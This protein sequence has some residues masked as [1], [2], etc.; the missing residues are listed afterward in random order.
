MKVKL[1]NGRFPED[2]SVDVTLPIE[3]E[4][5]DW[6]I[7]QLDRLGV[8]SACQR[9]C[10]FEALLEGPDVLNRLVDSRVNIEELDYLA[11]RLDS[12]TASELSTYSALALK[13]DLTDMTDLINLCDC[14]Q[15]AL[16][17]T[18]F[19][20][21]SRIG[22]Q[23]AMTRNGGAMAVDELEKIN[24]VAVARNL[25]S[26][27]AGT[28][29]PYGVLYDEG[30]RLENGYDEKMIPSFYYRQGLM[31]VQVITEKDPDN[32]P[33]FTLPMPGQQ[34]LR[35]LQRIWYREGDS[36]N[37]AMLGSE[38]PD[39]LAECLSTQGEDVFTLNK[40]VNAIAALDTSQ[41]E[42]LSAVLR[43]TG[44]DTLAKI[45]QA[46][47]NLD[48]FEYVHGAQ[49]ADDVGRHLILESGHFEVDPNLEDYI[50]YESYGLDHM[51]CGEGEFSPF[52]YVGYTGDDR[53]FFGMEH[54][55][56]MGGMT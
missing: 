34:I 46:A 16:I 28:V 5:Y 53:L 27:N 13:H 20:D 49:D 1:N 43:Y 31:D 23:Y 30:F 10:G 15:E 35:H 22:R 4:Q 44:A 48:M 45:Q 9:D 2:G 14:F 47:E 7:R 37:I 21:M 50:D 41:Y 29:T 52:G 39:D 12:F 54:H 18:D 51:R 11:K 25:L 19:S 26:G 42:K 6:V 38:F 8:G 17:V 33:E 3:P 40:T 36:Y 56:Q 32:C 55:Q 24:L